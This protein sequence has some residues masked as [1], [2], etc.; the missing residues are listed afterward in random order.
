MILPGKILFTNILMIMGLFFVLVNGLK[1]RLENDIKTQEEFEDVV[2]NCLDADNNGSN[3]RNK[4]NN[5]NFNNNNNNYNNNNNNNYR[6]W[7]Q[8]GNNDQRN[9]NNRDRFNQNNGN[10]DRNDDRNTDNRR[11]NNGGRR[12][13]PGKFN[14][15]D[16]N[17]NDYDYDND[18]WYNQDNKKNNNNNNNRRQSER[19][20][21][22]SYSSYGSSNRRNQ[23]N[24]SRQ[25]SDSFN[26]YFNTSRKIN[27]NIGSPLE[28]IDACVIHCIFRQMKMVG[29]ESYLNRNTVLN[30]LTRR[31]RDLEL[32]A[33]IQESVND[34]FENLDQ[35]EE[36]ICDY[37][38]SFAMCI[39]EKGKSNCDDWDM[40]K[41]GNKNKDRN[42][43]SN[44]NGNTFQQSRG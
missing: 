33:F 31:T 29:D 20:N 25:P 40:T 6:P 14:N 1:C 5:N 34:C 23:K 17:E 37:S 35:D 18:K 8:R 24:D 3:N 43:N 9:Q 32:K 7:N 42:N 36:E 26:N 28:D 21:G 19:N 12:K 10:R 27:S 13:Q 39:E 16:N 38:K 15:R 11:G 44:K 22:D 30:V 2:K 4:N 41:F